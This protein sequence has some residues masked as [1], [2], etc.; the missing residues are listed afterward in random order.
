[1]EVFFYD[2]QLIT[3]CM[4]SRYQVLMLGVCREA[5]DQRE[6]CINPLREEIRNTG[7]TE[8]EFYEKHNMCLVVADSK[9]AVIEMKVCVCVC[10]Y[11]HCI[12]LYYIVLI[13]DSMHYHTIPSHHD[14]SHHHYHYSLP[15]T[16][17][18]KSEK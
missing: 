9:E 18:L 3:E 2:W 14:Y 10:V 1:M 8:K 17:H 6:V 7:L 16:I 4:Y 11:L 5:L 13:I 15:G 12:V